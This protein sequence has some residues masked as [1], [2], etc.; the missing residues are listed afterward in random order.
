MV[1]AHFDF[2]WCWWY[3]VFDDL[4]DNPGHLITIEL[5]DGVLDLDL[6]DWGRRCHSVLCD[7]S[8]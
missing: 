4:P 8:V 5:H 7:E 2:P 1:G 6:L 3:L